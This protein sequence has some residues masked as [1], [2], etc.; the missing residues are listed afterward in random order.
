MGNSCIDQWN[1]LVRC[2]SDSKCVREHPD[3]TKAMKD[4]ASPDAQGVSA[5]CKAL[6]SAYTSCR[7]G[8][9]RMNHELPLNWAD[10]ILVKQNLTLI[11]GFCTDV[12]TYCV[13]G[14]E[15]TNPRELSEQDSGY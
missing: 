15:E 3:Q 12:R 10:C 11:V 7:L 2:L 1:K 8:Q 9:V 13:D 6:H 5:A 4:C 14:Y